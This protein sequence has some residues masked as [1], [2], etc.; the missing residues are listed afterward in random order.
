MLSK[1]LLFFFHELETLSETSVSINLFRPSPVASLA[2]QT[3]AL[4]LPPDLEAQSLPSLIAELINMAGLSPDFSQQLLASRFKSLK[5]IDWSSSTSLSSQKD[6]T[7]LVTASSNGIKLE[8]WRDALQ[9]VSLAYV[10]KEHIARGIKEL[11]V[12]HLTELWII[13]VTGQAQHIPGILNISSKV[14]ERKYS[15]TSA[16]S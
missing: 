8:R 7:K 2:A 14:S 3:F 6:K 9:N 4:P 12:A 15:E 13:S 11:V 1:F 16:Q 10:D 5:D